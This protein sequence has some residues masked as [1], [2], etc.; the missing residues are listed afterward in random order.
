MAIYIEK[1][2]LVNKVTKENAPRL[3]PG[4]DRALETEKARAYFPRGLHQPEGSFRFALDALLPAAFAATGP[5]GRMTGVLASGEYRLAD[6][7]AGCG[8]A[9]FAALL[10]DPLASLTAVEREPELCAALRH[11]AELLGCA[12]RVQVLEA[13]LAGPL[14]PEFAA[15]CAL[16]LANPPYRKRGHGRMPHNALRGRALFEDGPDTLPAF[17]RA[18]AFLLRQDGRFI[19]VYPP[20]RLPDLRSALESAGFG[21]CRIKAVRPRHDAPV[22]RLLLEAQKGA[23]HHPTLESDLIL[24]GDEGDTPSDQALVFCPELFAHRL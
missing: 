4:P 17:C 2:L 11:N 16:V 21:L 6:L 15:S 23:P 18:A 10:R 5:G 1:Q 13:D 20:E 12:E 14:P 9:G 8:V 19:L 22:G 3:A 24:Y 7:G